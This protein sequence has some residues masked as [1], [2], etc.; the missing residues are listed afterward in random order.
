[1]S[2]K[3]TLL[4]ILDYPQYISLVKALV[5]EGKT[6]GADQS[7]EMIYYTGL[8]LVRMERIKKTFHFTEE[9]SRAV[10]SIGQAYKFVVLTE[11]WCGDAAQV[12]PVLGAIAE[13]AEEKIE[14]QFL[15]R[16]ENPELMDQFLTNGG[17]SIPKVIIY[18]QSGELVTSWGPRPKVLQDY[19]NSLKESAEP[20]ELSQ[21]I[22]KVQL[23]YAKDR[24]LS[25]QHELA[26]LLGSL[27]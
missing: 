12:I 26:V 22:E 13:L 18:K 23:W 16:D 19:M 25:V 15:L 3:A 24:T 7:E 1:M 11:A 9:L 2:T 20:M 21:M 5:N 10:N 6:S 27:A 17:R 8:N 14:L 4:N